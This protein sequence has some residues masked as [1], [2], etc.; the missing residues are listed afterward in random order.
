M[1]WALI[2]ALMVPVLAL[3]AAPL[4]TQPKD[5]TVGLAVLA[6]IAMMAGGLYAVLGAP[7]L[8]GQAQADR[9]EAL[10]G[11]DPSSLSPQEII[12][13]LEQRVKVEPEDG[14]AWRH[15][16]TVRVAT[17]Q[18]AEGAE[19]YGR[20]LLVLGPDVDL[21]VR[22]AEARTQASGGEVTQSAKAAVDAALDLDPENPGALL[23]DGVASEQEGDVERAREIYVSLVERGE[24]PWAGLA[25]WQLN[26]V[27]GVSP[28]G[29]PAEARPG[30]DQAAMAAAA[31]MAPEDREAMI[32][33]M[34]AGLDS[35]LRDQPDDLG[36]WLRL[37]RSYGVLGRDGD[38]QD[39]I[40][41]ARVVFQDQPEA[42][43]Q[44]DAA[45]RVTPPQRN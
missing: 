38:R 23:L 44:I 2:A 19:A 33:Q 9:L 21:L 32:E 3:M 13:I 36:G 35:R 45:A 29:S 24:T 42:L 5:R 10:R 11:R 16:G 40:T 34:V 14:E 26:R 20:A 30:P 25:R 15:L 8:P 28:E 37:I 4:M 31:E 43:Q 1:I 18:F 39:A 17:G 41:R 12:F 22:L 6:L 7:N 27:D